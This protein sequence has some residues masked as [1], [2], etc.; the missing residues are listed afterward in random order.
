MRKRISGRGGGEGAGQVGGE[1]EAG[2]RNR[3]ENKKAII[4]HRVMYGLTFN[5]SVVNRIRLIMS[6]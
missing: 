2:K 6:N 1:G 5:W 4:I 3:G